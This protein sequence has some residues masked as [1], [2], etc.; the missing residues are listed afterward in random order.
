MKIIDAHVHTWTRDIISNTDLEARQIA[1]R[2]D[3]TEPLLD[4]PL[5]KL[6]ESM[7]KASIERAVVLPIDSGINQE[8]PLSLI[9][10]TNWHANEVKDEHAIRTFVGLDPRR[11]EIGVKELERAVKE[12]G[13]IG[14]KM[15]PPNGFYPDAD[16]YYPYYEKAV[17]LNIPI[18]IHC[19]FTSRFKHV[20]YAR[21]VYVDKVA[22]DFPQLKI[23][24]A[25][26]GTP[27]VDEALM[28]SAKN[29]N[30][31]VDVSGWQI[32]AKAAPVRLYEMIA[33]ARMVRVFPTRVIWGSDFPLFEHVMPMQ[34]WA[35]FFEKL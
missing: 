25:H 32:F 9:E 20:K 5:S 28:V 29:P 19:G 30:V 33:D 13:C 16:E 35:N 15:Y 34:D 1:A 17:E 3:G 21:P 12:Q 8:M 6:K 23:V 22:A 27:W 31:A 18:V 26:V 24:I 7:K 11:G 4:S 2:R 14:W 10:K